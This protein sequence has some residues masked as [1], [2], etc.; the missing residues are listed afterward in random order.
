MS[1]NL[2]RNGLPSSNAADEKPR[3]LTSLKTGFLLL[4]HLFV[5]LMLAAP[6]AKLFELQR[7][8]DRFF[9]AGAVIIDVLAHS[10]G[11][12]NEIFLSHLE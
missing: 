6:F 1:L 5:H 7:L 9:V 12:L 11:N 8:R 4:L 10:A 3:L 2:W